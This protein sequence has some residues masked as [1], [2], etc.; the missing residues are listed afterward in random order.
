MN[1]FLNT[2]KSYDYEKNKDQGDDLE[3][4]DDFEK[5]K[6]AFNAIMSN[7]GLNLGVMSG[8]TGIINEIANVDG[9][10]VQVQKDLIDLTIG[11]IGCI[12]VIG[13]LAASIFSI[14]WRRS[15]FGYDE[16]KAML[17]ALEK[18]IYKKMSQ[19]KKE[20][21]LLE[22][23]SVSNT[24]QDY[25]I[26]LNEYLKIRNKNNDIEKNIENATQLKII[27]MTRMEICKANI[28]RLT[29]IFKQ[30]EY[31]KDLCELYIQSVIP[32]VYL[33][34][35]AIR[36]GKELG[37]NDVHIK[38]F[39]DETDK[40]IEVSLKYYYEYTDKSQFKSFLSKMHEKF[41]KAINNIEKQYPLLDFYQNSGKK[42]PTYRNLTKTIVYF[43]SWYSIKKLMIVNPIKTLKI[44]NEKDIIY[45]IVLPQAYRNGDNN[46]MLSEIFY[47]G[48]SLFLQEDDKNFI[49]SF[50][51]FQTI[52]YFEI[53]CDNDIEVFLR[54]S[55]EYTS[56]WTF[57][58]KICENEY[59]DNCYINI[60]Q[61]SSYNTMFCTKKW[62]FIKFN[63]KF[64]IKSGKSY[65]YISTTNGFTP[66]RID[67][68]T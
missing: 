52:Q 48:N 16:T 63:Q 49:N 12:P 14:F 18:K 33:M 50:H 31:E 65:L 44:S 62:Y 67:I 4:K 1:N 10:Y 26:T 17:D 55:H 11:A 34:G 19:D 61:K 29:E 43:H 7:S 57:N 56:E 66:H 36:Y 47:L 9:D 5:Q 24:A 46:S 45:H 68:I 53:N 40:L 54:F 60:D 23:K 8:L 6:K 59:G 38:D 39:T 15:G 32:Y 35:D 42:E 64:T 27:L 41:I 28:F 37:Y 20:L 13:A 30:K 2:N 22:L 58:I 21:C 3:K 51:E 25:Y